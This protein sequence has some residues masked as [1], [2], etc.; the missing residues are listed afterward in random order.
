M[1][2]LA[3]PGPEGGGT[4]CL[5]SPQSPTPPRGAQTGDDDPGDYEEYED[6]SSLPDTR[7]IASDDSFYPP[8]GEEECGSGSAECVPEGVPEAATLLRAASTNDVGLL[9]ALVLRGPSS[10]EVRETDRN[11][12][13]L[14][15]LPPGDDV[16]KPSWMWRRKEE[17]GIGVTASDRYLLRNHWI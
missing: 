2:L 15:F 6:F 14:L 17:G 8:G 12:R 11:G 3:G 7:S 4:R 1:V 10:E 13:L 5:S 16:E 9:R